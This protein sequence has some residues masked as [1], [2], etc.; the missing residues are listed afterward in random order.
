MKR[1]III[2]VLIIVVA[3]STIIPYSEY[4]CDMVMLFVIIAVI[5]AVLFF[6]T[7]EK[8]SNIRRIFL[9]PSSLFVLTYLIVYF[10]R[11][12]DYLLG[13]QDG[14]LN[15]GEIKFMLPS[16]KYAIIG[17]CM[18][19]IGYLIYAKHDHLADRKE[20]LCK[21]KIVSL[22]A[23]ALLSSILIVLVLLIVPKEILMGGYSNDMLTNASV[24][25][26]LAS[27]C[28]TI[29]IAYVVQFTYRAKQT[30]ELEQCGVVQYIKKY[31]VWQNLNVVTYVLVILN[32]GDRGPLI[33]LIFSYYISFMVVSRKNISKIGITIA[34]C[35]GM[36]ITSL[37]GETKQY[38]DNNNIFD[39]LCSV[40][41]DDKIQQDSFFP[42]TSQ[43]AGSYCCLPIAMQMVPDIEDFSYGLS[44][45]G[46]V[47]VSIPFVGR[48]L[49]LPESSS[50]KISKFALGDYF[51]YG[52][53]TNCIASLYMDGGVIF[54][55]IGMFLFGVLIRKFE[56]YIFSNRTSSFFI[57]C[58]AFYFLSHIISIPRS[59]LLSPFKYALWM[60]LI[61]IVISHMAT[62]KK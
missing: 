56:V 60:Y 28:N 52:L 22:K 4:S 40:I 18:F 36:F 14:Y 23:F 29:L 8:N 45:V 59:T 42:M 6:I 11:P 55:T 33:A 49:S 37:L 58:L 32:V 12:V 5:V 43:L 7:Q 10:Q 41:K 39:R 17:L 34:L 38:R 3:L 48:L 31:G 62:R 16:L 30:E 53:G 46:D 61:I 26:Y 35:L 54:I 21:M 25:N 57:F 24:Y 44:T 2:I 27:W 47:I 1:E 50:Y 13:Y 51:S 20:E 9:R 19:L 15:L